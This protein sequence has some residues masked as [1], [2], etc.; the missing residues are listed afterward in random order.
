MEAVIHCMNPSCES[1]FW[2]A[3]PCHNETHP[4]FI[5][6]CARAVEDNGQCK[7]CKEFVVIGQEVGKL[8]EISRQK[9]KIH[10]ING[11]IHDRSDE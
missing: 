3:C 1:K 4:L 9:R 7:S 5:G 2:S 11:W 6:E 8:P 10:D